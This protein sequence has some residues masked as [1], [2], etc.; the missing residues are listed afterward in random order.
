MVKKYKL[1]R[2]CH[3]C[4]L[5]LKRQKEVH[6]PLDS[7]PFSALVTLSSCISVHSILELSRAN[8]NLHRK[9]TSRDFDASFWHYCYDH[10]ASPSTSISQ[11]L[12]SESSSKNHTEHTFQL[13]VQITGAHDEAETGTLYCTEGC[14]WRLAY[15]ETVVI[16]R[17]LTCALAFLR[18]PVVRFMCH[19]EF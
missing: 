19:P 10:A 14:R 3:G 1:Q 9:L 13:S 4:A 5:L 2:V 7:L 6:S 16:P 17:N 11:Y 12:S 18:Y 8:K 15:I